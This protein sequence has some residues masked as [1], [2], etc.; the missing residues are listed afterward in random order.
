MKRGTLIVAVLL[1]AVSLGSL[2]IGCQKKAEEVT[3]KPADKD[4]IV[5]AF[6]S[7]ARSLDPHDT[8]DQPSARV[9]KQL[10]DTLMHQA[11]DLS[12][13]KGLVKEYNVV[14]PTLYEFELVK[15]VKFHNGEELKA[16]DVKFTFERMREK[17]APAAFLV[18]ALDKVT[19]T[20]DYTFTMELKYPFGPFITH[21][22]HTA[23]SILNEKAVTEG[24]ENYNRAPVGTGPFSFVEWR[25]GD[26]IRL[27]RYEDYYKGPAKSAKITFRIIPENAQRAIAIETAEADLAYDVD[28]RDFFNL[29]SQD[30]IV[31]LQDRGL[32]T[33]YLGFNVEKKP[34]DDVRVRQAI[35]Y[36]LDTEQAIEVVWMGAAITPK[37]PLAPNVQF[38]RDDLDG[39]NY[40][41]EKAKELLAE[42]GYA[43]GFTTT[44][45]TNDNP[46]RMRYAEI[47]QEQLRQVGI[48]TTIEVLEWAAY[49]N[50]TA[51][52]EHDM[53]ILGWVAVTGDADYGMYAL[54]HSTQFG[55][56][57]NRTFYKNEDVDAALDEGRVSPDP[58]ARRAAYYRAQEL[59]M[60]DAPWVFMYVQDVLTLSRD[61][62]EGFQ[63]HAA[64]HH[65]LYG[66]SNK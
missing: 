17:N 40:D 25:P 53:F 62:V 16:S 57:G 50:R 1:F 52:G 59:V 55:D 43:D 42:A 8:N 46:I 21:L 15:G 3:G 44:L 7:D 48:E 51:A 31:G 5:I 38:A 34:F 56:A 24:G 13:S 10:Y 22:A 23:T 12:I 19:V 14:S 61:Y 54:F 30:G 33:A 36:A 26:V 6:P 4:T 32:S 63:N 45:W 64:G 11:P 29:E 65:I 20:G 35:N 58:E 9:M 60:E 37:S 27:E 66:V 2:L 39:Y 41:P 18:A 49:L 28:P 47:F